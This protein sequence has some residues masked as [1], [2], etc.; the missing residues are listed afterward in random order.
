MDEAA[1]GIAT[2][3]LSLQSMLLQALVH[4]GVLSREDAL[5]IVDRSLEAAANAPSAEEAGEVAEITQGC[6]VGVLG[7]LAAMPSRQ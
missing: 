5:G 2:A 6:L 1:R 4:K 7:R 3:A